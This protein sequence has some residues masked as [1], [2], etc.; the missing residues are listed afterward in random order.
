MKAIDKLMDKLYWNVVAKIPLEF[1]LG[2]GYVALA[3][4]V[5]MV[6]TIVYAALT[7][8]LGMGDPLIGRLL[9]VPR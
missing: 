7:S 5:I 8:P 1:M 4:M 3:G 9:G 2:V 6:A